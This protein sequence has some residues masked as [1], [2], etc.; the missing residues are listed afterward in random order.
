MQFSTAVRNARLDATET[1]IGATAVLRIF[2][3]SAPAATTDA[4][5]GTELVEMTLPA[6][7]MA[8]ASGGSKV[9]A[10]SW[11]DTAAAAGDAGYFRIYDSTGTTCGIQGTCSGTGGGGEMTLN[12][13]SIAVSQVVTV[14]TFTLTEGN[15]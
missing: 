12:N 8:A 5:S 15:A 13:A 11:S 14:V 7:W 1:A 10:G 3:G 2:T 6:D 4:D 9:L